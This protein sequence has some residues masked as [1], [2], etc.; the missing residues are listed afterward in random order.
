L[1]PL[2][3][4]SVTGTA[5][6]TVLTLVP[7]LSP[8]KAAD[9]A[10][11]PGPAS[12]LLAQTIV[13]DIPAQP[14]AGALDSFARRTGWQLGYTS[15]LTMGLTSPGVQGTMG[16]IEALDRLLAGSGLTHV[17]T[18]PGVITLE[19]LAAGGKET[20]DTLS[21][22]ALRSITSYEGTEGYVSYYS[23]AATK[24]DTPILET[25][26]SISVIARQ[27]IA[28]RNV[29]TVAEAVRYSPG[30]LVDHYG[31]DPRGY[32][33]INIRGFNSVTT[34]SF[35]DGLRMVGNFFAA[36]S[37]EPYGIERVDIMRGPSGAL[38]GQ[39]EAGGVIDRTTKRP[40]ADMRQEV[41]IEGGNWNTFQG[42]F[43]LGGAVTE[44]DDLLFRLTGLV[45][46]ADTEFD[47]NDGSEQDD[48]RI[49][50]APA[51]TWKPTEDTEL[52]VMANYLK[53]SRGTQFNT[54]ANETVGLTDVVAGEPGFD[55]FK[56]EQFDVGYT[57]SHRFDE[58]WSVRQ[59]A[60]YN[61][62]DV[63]YQAVV[64]DYLDADGVTLHRYTWASPDVLNQVAIDNQVQA[65]FSAGPTD[66]VL[67]LGADYSYSHDAFSYHSGAADSLDITNV[68][69]SGNATR[70]DAY[71][72]TIQRLSQAGVYFQD[73]ITL[74]DNLI[75]TLGGRYTWM[76]QT[77]EQLLSDTT[78]TKSDRAFTGRAGI[79]YVFDNGIA[80]YF[81][82]TQGFVPTE[83]ASVD[84]KT[85]D[86]Q[87]SEQYE[88]GVK[89]QPPG[90]N[91]LFTAAAFRTT[92]TNVLTRDPEDINNS[93]LAGEIRAQGVELEA[94]A[95]LFDG[96][97]MSLSYTYT[98]SEVTKS[99]DVDL[100]KTPVLVPDH[101]ASAWLGYTFDGGILKGLGLGAGARYVGSTFNDRANTSRSPEYVLVDAMARYDLTEN[102][103][104]QVNVNNLLDTEYITTCAYSSC[105]YG[106]GLRANARLTYSW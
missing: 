6:A 19:P 69:Y 73:Q 41:F 65:E 89:Y 77:T 60:R 64:A 14:L 2:V 58:T 82:F 97:D 67:L 66:H 63:D 96:W 39:A 95:S 31:V 100:G 78:E 102:A 20:I 11:V 49:Y 54:F 83:G 43:D 30:V 47:Y 18:A 85:Y 61:R 74:Y 101:T 9:T 34:G 23:V 92:K 81:G 56:Q 42:G 80:P 84:G 62:T 26:Q 88:V 45:R 17:E 94:K 72:D 10:V 98:D 44:D 76:T 32:D 8:A 7:H 90:F 57:I 48:D 105:Y 59:V 91:A 50:I 5:L 103:R 86:P 25:P 12:A 24:S 68:V 40:R 4:R 79:T 1:G 38:Y 13:F 71:Q 55:E 21:I 75:L 37:T 15:D 28:D 33:S 46:Q 29:K 22:E 70:P 87:R 53:D 36:P 27:E 104:V 52:T 3:R 99:N 93:V 35:R 106:P 51:V 16:A